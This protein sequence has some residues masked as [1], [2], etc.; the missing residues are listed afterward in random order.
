LLVASCAITTSIQ[1]LTFPKLLLSLGDPCLGV[2]DDV[3][4]VK[5]VI[6]LKIMPNILHADANF[7]GVA[8]VFPS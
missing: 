2:L 1:H 4:G 5:V 3:W 6:V 7:V 8:L